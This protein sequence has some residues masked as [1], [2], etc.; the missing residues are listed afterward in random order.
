VPPRQGTDTP[1]VEGVT[2]SSHGAVTLIHTRADGQGAAPA[3]ATPVLDRVLAEL[4]A[5]IEELPTHRPA[6]GNAGVPL[7]SRTAVLVLLDRRL[8]R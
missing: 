6:M 7:V 5:A 1:R 2:E 8:R 3:H 4:A